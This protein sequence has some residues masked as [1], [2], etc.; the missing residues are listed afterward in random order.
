MMGVK[1]L[2]GILG[3]ETFKRPGL[4]AAALILGEFYPVGALM[5][6]P[7]TLLFLSKTEWVASYFPGPI[8]VL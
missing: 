4:T 3:A 8:I 6:G 2:E 5:I 7:E 1:N